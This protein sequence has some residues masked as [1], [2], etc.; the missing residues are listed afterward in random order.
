VHS[1]AYENEPTLYRL[2]A[3]DVLPALMRV[4]GAA[5]RLLLPVNGATLCHPVNKPAVSDKFLIYLEQPRWELATMLPV[6]AA[7]DDRGG[8]MALA[9]QAAA[10]AQCRVAT[11]G[12]GGGKSASRSC[13]GKPGLI[14]SNRPSASS[15]SRRSRQ[16]RPG[17]VRQQAPPPSRDGGPEKT[18]DPPARRA[19]AGDRVLL[20]SMLIKLFHGIQNYGSG[21]PDTQGQPKSHFINAMTF[22]ETVACMKKLHGLGVPRLY[23][24]SVGWGPRGHDGMWPTRF[25]IERRLGGEEA[26]ARW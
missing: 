22:D 13:C 19:V 17:A 16:S 20:T 23:T 21:V 9:T 24:Q 2:F 4:S 6:A 15:A 10:E 1:E 8:L 12:K 5:S 3:V 18:D 11:D 26:S 25:P 7:W 14:R